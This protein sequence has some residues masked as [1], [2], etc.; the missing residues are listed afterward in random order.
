MANIKIVGGEGKSPMSIKIF[1]DGHEMKD[2]RECRLEFN[3]TDF[4]TVSMEIAATGIEAD[5]EALM[6]LNTIME[7]DNGP[8]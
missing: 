1:V 5:V 4:P 8:S 6:I 3:R 7:Y 2:V